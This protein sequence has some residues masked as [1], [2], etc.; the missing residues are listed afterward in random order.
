MGP[1][2]RP[3]AGTRSESTSVPRPHGHT[4]RRERRAIVASGSARGRPTSRG[5]R[6][7]SPVAYTPRAARAA[8]RD[9][10]VRPEPLFV[11][12]Q[13]RRPASIFMHQHG[14]ATERRHSHADSST[15][16]CAFGLT[17]PVTRRGGVPPRSGRDMVGR[18]E[19]LDVDPR[20]RAERLRDPR[21][22]QAGARRHVERR[23]LVQVAEGRGRADSEHATGDCRPRL[24]G[25][26]ARG[27][28]TAVSGS[29]GP[30]S[31][32]LIRTAGA[33]ATRLAEIGGRCFSRKMSS[34]DGRGFS[35]PGARESGF[36]RSGSRRLPREARGPFDEGFRAGL[37]DEQVG[38]AA[39]RQVAG[40]RA[41]ERVR[42]P[43]GRS[44]T[45]VAP[46]AETEAVQRGRVAL[47]GRSRSDGVPGNQ[48]RAVET[49]SAVA[50]AGP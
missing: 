39:W 49:G 48:G 42:A 19:V 12:A 1:A 29:S 6:R 37:V 27:G 22:G 24:A 21:R 23:P 43:A 10:L 20:W 38:E 13:R 3:T 25:S 28:K 16:S 18:L 47:R 31:R 4:E 41:T 8:V 14:P 30:D 40:E 26:R 2:A 15:A 34:S 44:A 36:S 32:L 7:F 11:A 5:P 46:S 33:R 50:C 17:S 35:R 45:D 9:R